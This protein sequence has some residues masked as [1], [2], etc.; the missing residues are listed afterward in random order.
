MECENE[1]DLNTKADPAGTGPAFRPTPARE[2][3]PEW[4]VWFQTA[5]IL[6]ADW[7]GVKP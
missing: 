5:A 2:L 7:Q 6:H 3:R 1:Y 4:R